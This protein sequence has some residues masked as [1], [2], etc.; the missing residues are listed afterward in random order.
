MPDRWWH[1]AKGAERAASPRDVR[2]FAHWN[3]SAFRTCA[4]QAGQGSVPA[5]TQ[6]HLQALPSGRRVFPAQ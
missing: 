4:A 6:A 1:N 2:S 3:M 5:N